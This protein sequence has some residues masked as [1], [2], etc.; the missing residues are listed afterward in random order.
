MTEKA[1]MCVKWCQANVCKI[2]FGEPRV[3]DRE[4]RKRGGLNN[5][6]GMV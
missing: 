1:K 5:L 3:R 4:E 2:E 6:K